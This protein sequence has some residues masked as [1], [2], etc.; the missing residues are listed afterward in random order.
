[1]AE[2][3][4]IVFVP[5]PNY[6]EEWD[7]YVTRE[8]HL[9][10]KRSY[11]NGTEKFRKIGYKNKDGYIQF[12]IMTNGIR[13]DGLVHVLIVRTFTA[14]PENKPF[15]DHKNGDRSD[16][17]VENLRYCTNR[18]NCCNSKK[19]GN[20]SSTYKGVSWDKTNNKWVSYIQ[21]NGKRKSLGYFDD[22]EDAAH[23]YDKFAR[24]YYGEFARLNFPD[25][26]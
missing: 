4:E 11:K 7:I 2:A 22:E 14:N 1:M 20:T 13:L 9:Y 3:N 17:R 10:R 5:V 6:V 25:N 15:I 19:Q 18:E 21:I 16:N 24:K 23:V 12:H 8:G 26:N